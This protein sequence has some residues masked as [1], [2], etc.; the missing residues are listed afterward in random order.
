MLDTTAD[1]QLL[2]CKGAPAILQVIGEATG[3][4]EVSSEAVK[5]SGEKRRC[6]GK[7]A[8]E[9]LLETKVGWMRSPEAST[10]S[11]KVAGL[12][13]RLRRG[14][15]THRQA[16]ARSS[17]VVSDDGSE[18][19]VAGEKRRGHRSR[20]GGR[21]WSVGALEQNR[22]CRWFSPDSRVTV[23]EQ[24]RMTLFTVGRNFKEPGVG[25]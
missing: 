16:Q 10:G 1:E 24:C 2:L 15:R 12:V 3:A 7:K 8:V 20:P 6:S 23:S 5:K 25:C 4:G 18:R 14:R 11:G 13:D 22:G 17:D 19:G 21:L 9:G